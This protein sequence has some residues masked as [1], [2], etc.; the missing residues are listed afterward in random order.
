MTSTI[1][2]DK[3]LAH[4]SVKVSR[5]A[6]KIELLRDEISSYNSLIVTTEGA[7]IRDTSSQIISSISNS[8]TEVITDIRPNPDIDHLDK[9][10]NEFRGRDIQHIIAL[11]GGSVIDAAKIFSA[12]LNLNIENILSSHF[13]QK[14]E[15][16]WNNF[17]EITAIP[18]TSGTGSE[19]TPFATVWDNRNGEKYSYFS[20]E[21]LPR[22]AFLIPELTL[23]LKEEDTIFPALDALSHSLESIWNVKSNPKIRKISEKSIELIVKNLPLVISEPSNLEA[24]EI[25]QISSLLAGLA[26]SETKT[27]IAHSISYPLTN[28]CGVPHGLACSFTLLA[29]INLLESSGKTILRNDDIKVQLI[30]FLKSLKLDEKIISYVTKNEILKLIPEMFNPERAKNFV[31]PLSHGDIKDI[32]EASV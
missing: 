14:K 2:L 24:R 13:R 8:F 7:L 15:I 25:L 11:G 10:I 19:V 31:I 20:E 26:I 18:T 1:D 17:I 21:V 12:T 32:I 6:K 5:G 22:S 3:Y 29:L 30:H 28:K 27:A 9:I 4:T 23:S 16:T